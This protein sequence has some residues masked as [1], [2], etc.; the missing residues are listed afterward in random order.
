MR[1]LYVC[2]APHVSPHGETGAAAHVRA[3]TRALTARGHS[4]VLACRRTDG[5]NRLAAGVSVA[6]MPEGWEEQSRWLVDQMRRLGID[7]VIERYSLRS[8]PA[9]EAVQRWPIPLLLEVSA[10]LVD[11]AARSGGLDDVRSWRQWESR[12]FTSVDHVVAASEVIAWHV[13]ATGVPRGNVSVVPNGVDP[14]RFAGV[15]GHSV[16]LE[17][18]LRRGFVLGYRGSLDAGHG[19]DTVVDAMALLP[20]SMRLLVIGDGSEREEIRERARW[21]GVSGRVVLAGDVPESDVPAFLAAVNCGIA[22]YTDV[23]RYYYSPLELLEYCAAGLPIVATAQGEATQLG[24]AA[25][26]V[27]PG[28]LEGLAEAVTML[29]VDAR[30]RASM[31]AAARAYAG[32]RTWEQA[33]A[34]IEEIVAGVRVTD[35]AHRTNARTRVTLR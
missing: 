17:Y 6:V 13:L 4:V 31:S 23:E 22:P 1:I 18:D 34:R 27:Q 29:A 12:L 9:V 20:G 26:L 35:R 32:R 2:A 24:G 25:L 21:R 33:A 10:P 15:E 19:L 7:V 14:L 8:G 16:R 11:D 30:L 5:P 3:V 28:D